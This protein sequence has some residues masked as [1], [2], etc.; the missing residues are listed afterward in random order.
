MN[1]PHILSILLLSIF[2]LLMTTASSDKNDRN[3][4]QSF[5]VSTLTL[6][7]SVTDGHPELTWNSPQNVSY[8]EL[9]R[10]PTPSLGGVD[11]EEVFRLTSNS[12]LD[13]AVHGAVLGP[14][15]DQVR[16][17]IE[18]FDS[19]GTLIDSDGP[20]DYTADYID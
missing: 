5:N 14:G 7:G 10:I 8:Y 11:K 18:A 1:K 17:Q 12:F 20:V 2:V 4:E 6:S 16:Y 13:T 15:F 3:S 19:G 9:H